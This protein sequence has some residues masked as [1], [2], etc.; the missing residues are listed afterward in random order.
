M[1]TPAELEAEHFHNQDATVAQIQREYADLI[2]KIAPI[3]AADAP[4]AVIL[5]KLDQLLTDTVKNITVNIET[6]M[7]K[8]WDIANERSSTIIK[9]KYTGIKLPEHVQAALDDRRG[10]AA[11]QF[12]RRRDSGLNLSDRVWK[13]AKEVRG[14]VERKLDEGIS[15]GRSAASIAKELRTSLNDGEPDGKGGRYASPKKNTERLTRTETNMSYRM[16]DQVGWSENPL[17]L[18]YRVSLSASAKPKI[19]CAVC[20]ALEGVYPKTFVFRTWHPN[21]LCFT[22][23][24]LMS[25]KMLDKYNRLIAQGKDTPEAYAK[26]VRGVLVKEPHEG[27]K[28]WVRDNAE[29]LSVAK[30]RPYFWEDNT[31]IITKILIK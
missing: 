12:Q 24:I 22:T 20:R 2:R 8:S 3:I 9:D 1:K 30:T 31:N 23:P 28:S 18:G 26:L 11:K 17:V 5:R 19:R 7:Q 4:R 29:R 14:L 6:G 25:R 21:C 15:K 27:F 10:K 16:A 13:Q